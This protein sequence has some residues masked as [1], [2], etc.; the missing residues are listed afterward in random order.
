MG[1]SHMTGLNQPIKAWD[2]FLSNGK[3]GAAHLESHSSH[4]IKVTT[5]AVQQG[6]L[7]SKLL[8]IA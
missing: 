5:S 4:L 3:A 6:Q 2:V 1:V 8:Y 7:I